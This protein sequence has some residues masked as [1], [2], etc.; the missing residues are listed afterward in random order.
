MGNAGRITIKND[1]S[2]TPEWHKYFGKF[3]ISDACSVEKKLQRRN[4]AVTSYL[5][6]NSFE[7]HKFLVKYSNLLFSESSASFIKGKGEEDVTVIFAPSEGFLV[8]QLTKEDKYLGRIKKNFASCAGPLHEDFSDCLARKVADELMKSEDKISSL[9]RHRDVMSYKLRDYTCD[10]ESMKSSL[11]I[12]QMNFTSNDVSYE[13]DILFDTQHA[14]V[15]TVSNFVSKG[16]CKILQD[17]GRDRL[18]KA[19][20]A[21]VD[22][23]PSL[24]KGRSAQQAG[25]HP[26]NK[27]PNDP[28]INLRDKILAVTN[29]VA[30]YDL[31]HQGQEDF[32]IIQYN[33]DDQYTAHCDGSCDGKMYNPGGRVATAIMYC[34]V[35]DVGGGT[36]F[37]KADLFVKPVQGMATFFSYKGVDGI[38]DEG[39]TEHSGC[40][41]IKGEKWIT[42]FWMRDGVTEGRPWLNFDPHGIVTDYST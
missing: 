33:K 12:R 4:L 14:K 34:Q 25:Y 6:F 41:V 28:L 8:S 10:D 13:T 37:T 5:Q 16:E 11:P 24:S 3:I 26:I 39:F 29:L 40:P 38:M 22:G 7:G 31:Q 15:W 23:K 32:T 20:V 19:T 2:S 21:G 18:T 35:A 30:G 9:I 1:F 36:T 27:D 42:T 17:Y